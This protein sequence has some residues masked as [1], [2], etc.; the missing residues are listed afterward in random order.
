M[1][2]DHIVKPDQGPEHAQLPDTSPQAES[3]IDTFSK[4]IHHQDQELAYEVEQRAGR[5][6]RLAYDFGLDKIHDKV[7]DVAYLYPV[8]EQLLSKRALERKAAFEAIRGFHDGESTTDDEKN[9]LYTYGIMLDFEKINNFISKHMDNL[10]SQTSLQLGESLFDKYSSFPVINPES[11]HQ[12]IEDDEQTYPDCESVD[13][14]A[15][16]IQALAVY[17]SFQQA[18]HNGDETKL[19]ELT[20]A[21]EAFYAPMCEFIGFDAI[22]MAVR[23]CTY[24][25]RLIR[26]TTP[27]ADGPSGVT[28]LALARTK[29]NIEA[30]TRDN[31][32]SVIT[33]IMRDSSIPD[34]KQTRVISDTYGHGIV[35][36]TGEGSIKI[37]ED[38]PAI[39]VRFTW[40]KKTPGSYGKKTERYDNPHDVIAMTIITGS[41]TSEEYDDD[42]AVE[43]S[44]AIYKKLLEN[45]LNSENEYFNPLPADGK[46]SAG[47]IK[48]DKEFIKKITEKI[49]KTLIEFATELKTNRY[50]NVTLTFTYAATTLNEKGDLVA[51]EIP[52]EIQI[53]TRD[54]RREARAGMAS[55]VYY[56]SLARLALGVKPT[57]EDTISELT[58]LAMQ[59]IHDR[60]HRMKDAVLTERSRRDS[61][62]F[63]QYIDSHPQAVLLTD[64]V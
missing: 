21:I 6:L 29:L 38:Q 15:I 55:H 58:L 2:R 40:R 49:P 61:K 13:I 39:D 31:I 47:V 9:R 24:Q 54:A 22:S 57:V 14:E 16:F 53:Q 45:V 30:L 20:Y 10:R 33:D 23:D 18:L 37:S 63:I 25:L 44:A 59:E 11:L 60:R 56:K 17:D 64:S 36:G 3:A 34:N 52:V 41:D 28:R 42:Q 43:E 7:Y 1:I 26:E 19:R 4:R 50:Q 5:M 8:M 51:E 46:T 32:A 27:K 12:L 35:F 48:G 62:R